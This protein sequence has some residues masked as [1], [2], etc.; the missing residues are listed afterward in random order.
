MRTLHAI[1]C[2]AAILV[3]GSLLLASC[4]DL[5]KEWNSPASAVS[6]VHPEDWGK[7]GTPDFH[8][9][10]LKGKNWKETECTQCHGLTY[11]GGTSGV[12]C[13]PCHDAYPHSVKFT[14]YHNG[15]LQQNN[16]P[17]KKCQLCHGASYN[18]GSVVTVG[19]G[20][21]SFCHSDRNGA[22]KSPEACNTCHGVFRAPASDFPSAAPPPSVLGDT[23]T[24]VSGVGAH[25]KHVATGV[26]GR[27]VK[28][29]ECHIVP[30][31]YNSPGH[32]NDLPTTPA[33]VVLN[34]TLANLPTAAGKY[35]PTNVQYD[36][37]SG[38]C[39]NTYCHGNWVATRRSAPPGAQYAYADTA[40]FGERMNP[41]WTSSKSG[42]CGTCHGLPPE[43]HVADLTGYCGCHDFFN[44]DRS[45]KN[46][47]KHMN[48]KINL[49]G[50]VERAF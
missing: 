43:G 30:P 46:R 48:G 16:F 18:G 14:P 19:C 34:D 25:Q 17:L 12:S 21:F 32:L 50:G 9:V 22:P 40:I 26:M 3:L 2:P 41:R 39:T 29:A 6:T 31:A 5:K 8:G 28:C 45:I 33:T 10:Y 42:A 27:T 44:A 37:A 15:Y 23:A 38:N 7:A 13:F 35:V 36:H 4:G 24:T 1:L 11:A 49:A 47:S 20:E